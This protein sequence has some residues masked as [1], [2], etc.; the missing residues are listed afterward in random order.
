MLAI[1][2]SHPI[3]YQVPIWRALAAAGSVPFEVWYLTDHGVETSRDAE[4]GKEFAWDL[5]LLSGYPHRFL[6][7]NPDWSLRKFRGVRLRED[8]A[9]R[10]RGDNVCALWIE[11]WRFSALW[12]AAVLARRSGVRVWMRGESN[13]IRR[14]PWWKSL[15]KRTILG[16]H[17]WG[18]DRFLCIGA[19][20]R[21]L[22]ESYGISSG[23]M[24]S[25]PYCVD[26]DRFAERAALLRRTRDEV[27][28]RWHVPH[29]AFCLLF[30][31]KFIPKKRPGDVV[32]AAKKLLQDPSFERP[33][34]LLFV[35]CGELGSQLRGGCRV[36]FDAEGAA[37]SG[38][39]PRDSAPD[40]SFVGF[41]NQTEIPAAYVAADA[42]VLPSDSGETW[43]LVVN[44]AMACGIPTIVSDRC[45]CAEDLPARIDKRL[46][47]PFGDVEEL[48]RAMRFAIEAAISKRSIHEAVDAHHFRHTVST[49]EALYRDLLDGQDISHSEIQSTRRV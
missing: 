41:L 46:V 49:V 30:C 19:A 31:G 23:K 42:L 24:V 47:F 8:L 27:R 10:M 18:I 4:F 22:Y 1:L 17:L 3:Q 48:A 45:G 35:G 36:R 14:D 12:K 16:R 9:R 37:L 38:P 11:G 26:N 7:V 39:V 28:A 6:Q 34:H 2:T 20:N 13:D 29:D 33:L 40:A 44:E 43:G 21:R 5:D 25:A 15:V 32:E